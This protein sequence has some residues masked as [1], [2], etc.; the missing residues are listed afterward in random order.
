MVASF[1]AVVTPFAEAIFAKVSMLNEVEL[2][3]R[4]R[5]R[6]RS[7]ILDDFKHLGNVIVPENRPFCLS[8][9]AAQKAKVRGVN[10]REQDWYDQPKFDEGRTIFHLEHWTPNGLMREACLSAASVDEIIEIIREQ[11]GLAWILKSEDKNLTKLGFKS[12]RD[13]PKAAY[14]EAGIVL[15]GGCPGWEVE[16]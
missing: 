5:T 3:D 15:E 10:I 1:E 14:L 12:K 8:V 6:V 4:Q 7:S 13:D 16:S 11:F 2:T 9:E